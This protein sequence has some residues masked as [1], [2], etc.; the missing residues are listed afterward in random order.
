MIHLITGKG[1][2]GKSTVA[3]AMAWRLAANGRKTLLVEF[4]ERSFYRHIFQTEIGMTPLMLTTHL[5]VTRWEGEACLREY[6]QHFLKIEK[7]VD[8]FFDNKIMR[9]LIQAAP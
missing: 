3:A 2:V 4:G 7:L 6:L 8:L 5:S 9:A 1:G